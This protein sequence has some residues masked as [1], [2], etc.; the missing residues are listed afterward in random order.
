MMRRCPSVLLLCLLSFACDG[1]EKP[2]DGGLSAAPQKRDLQRGHEVREPVPGSPEA[3]R[4]AFTR[5]MADE[6]APQRERALIQIAWNA[7]EIDPG[8]AAEALL[9]LPA[10]SPEKL[11]LI[12]HHA[13]RLAETDPEGA[14]AWADSVGSEKEVA[15]AIGQI[16]IQ[17]AE[18]DPVRAANL[19]SESGIAGRDFDVAVVQ[20]IQRWCGV[21]PRD[22]A[23]WVSSFPSGAA[24]EAGI[25]VVAGRWLP[26]DPPA[27]F[28]WF[29]SLEEA[30][31]R[32]EAARAFEGVILQ[33]PEDVRNRWINH[34]DER[35]RLELE[36][37]RGKA[38]RDVG[39]NIPVP[40]G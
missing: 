7:I 33:Q 21:A 28:A 10:D 12:Q 19:L 3:L 40:Q 17:L 8:L 18:A 13:M 39:D 36:Q 16:A 11:K 37:Q 26:I 23:A 9:R 24:R 35:I 25:G 34:T 1:R 20:V 38:M 27:A 6:S 29:D 32:G 4:D 2:A 14:L 15:A 30:G 22:A 31:L 5:A